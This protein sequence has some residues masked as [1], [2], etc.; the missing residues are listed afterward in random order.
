LGLASLV[1]IDLVLTYLVL[2]YLG[3][4]NSTVRAHRRHLHTENLVV[5]R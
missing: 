3:H 5:R 2:A 4:G 1:L